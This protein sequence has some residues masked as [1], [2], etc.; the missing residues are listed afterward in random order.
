MDDASGEKA[1]FATPPSMDPLIS[2]A[3]RCDKSLEPAAHEVEKNN[4]TPSEIVYPGT[5]KLVLILS[6]SALSI[7]LVALDNT[8]ISTAIPRITDDFHSLDDVAW[9]GSGFL[10]TMAAF[11]SMWGKAYKYFSVKLVSLVAILVFE[12]GSLICAVAPNS[13]TLIVGRAIAGL[14]GAGI[15][16]GSYLIVALS[17]PPSKMPALQGVISASFA[18]AS[19][20]GPLVGGAFTQDVT[21]RWCFWINLPIGGVAFVFITIFYT[22]PDHAKPVRATWREKLLQMDFVGTFLLLASVICFLLAMQWGG[23][24]KAW[25]SSD[26]IG[27]LIGAGLIFIVWIFVEIRLGERA[28]LNIRL[29]KSRTIQLLML[30]QSTLCSCFFIL[31][32]YL[33]IYFQAVS[34]VTAASSGVRNIPLIATSC[35]FT[36]LSGL[37]ISKTG[38]FQQLMIVGNIL[39]TVGSGL[40][41]TL[42][43]GSSA[44]EWI[45]YQIVIGVGLGLS[46]QV[47]VVVCQSIV[48]PAD[49]SAAS[50]MV[51]FFQLGAASVWLSIA[52]ALFGNKLIQLLAQDFGPTRGNQLF[53]AGATALRSLLSGEAVEFAVQGYVAGLKDAY[54]VSIALAGFASIVVIAAIFVDRRKLRWGTSAVGAT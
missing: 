23:V 20:A 18:I 30:H 37:I 49:L 32:Y 41:Y 4:S 12:I 44:G 47:A 16:S 19:V 38:E 6:V 22:T 25:S 13:T 33:P 17:A 8:I 11:Q 35:I 51:L 50:A 3:G 15:G 46:V 9:Y 27:T 43:A 7:F 54:V 40:I 24:D 48:D 2:P 39:V 1:S 28:A 52:Q 29:L 53:A 21:W 10:V 45:G 5:L 31:L 14:G 26:V 42:D 36:I 34:G